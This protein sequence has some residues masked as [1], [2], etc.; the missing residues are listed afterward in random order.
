MSDSIAPRVPEYTVKSGDCL[1][2]IARSQGI[3]DWRTIYDH[4]NNSGFKAKRPN[5]NVIYPGDVLFLPE[6]VPKTLS[7]PT[8]KRHQYLL[9]RQQCCLRLRLT[10]AN[11]EA[12]ADSPYE[13]EV[14]GAKYSGRTDG[15][16]KL[17]QEI[18]PT[19]AEGRLTVKAQ[20][21][22]EEMTLK[23]TLHLGGLDPVE[24]LTGLQAR[25]NNL[26]YWCGEVDGI[27]GP[28]TQ[29][30]I[31]RFHEDRELSHGVEIT[32][33]TRQLLVQEAGL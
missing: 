15:E 14:D 17:V 18:E 29:S 11:D 32:D 4:P 2:S 33:E 8:G 19:A 20:V 5:P 12:F 16:G 1:Y 27:L 3:H 9:D 31:Q 22:G 25:L 21:N 7:A 24:E 30:A 28:L 26:G 23:W 6:P 13:L 10:D